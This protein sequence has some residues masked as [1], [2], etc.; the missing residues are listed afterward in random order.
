M[1]KTKAAGN[2]RE[3]QVKELLEELGYKV[4]KARVSLGPADLVATPINLLQTR[5]DNDV[6]LPTKK[7]LV[8]VKA[9]KGNA[10]MNFR[11]EERKE[12]L[13][14]AEMAGGT[15]VLCH[16]PPYGERKWLFEKDW[17]K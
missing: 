6:L 11:K 12:L 7:L 3:N 17:P 5:F 9:N 1:K 14:E 4:R 8:Q 13:E 2:R 10:Y 15:A 16:W